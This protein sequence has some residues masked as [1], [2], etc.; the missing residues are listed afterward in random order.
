M[1]QDEI[2][3]MA[4]ESGALDYY[5]IN[6]GVDGDEAALL[7]FA[8]LVADVA[9]AKER[10]ACAQLCDNPAMFGPE[11]EWCAAAIRDRGQE[12]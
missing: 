6:L 9:T 11:G 7:A 8:K 3:D 4:R 2:I 12:T 5:E 10:E 1:T